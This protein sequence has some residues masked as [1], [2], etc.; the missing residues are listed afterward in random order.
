MGNMTR[1]TPMSLAVKT[2]QALVTGACKQFPYFLDSST[3]YALYSNP[4]IV[5][6]PSP[7]RKRVRFRCSGGSF[8]MEGAKAADLAN[9]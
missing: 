9:P 8:S 5:E 2:T 7:L 4:R 1:A 6:L 3:A